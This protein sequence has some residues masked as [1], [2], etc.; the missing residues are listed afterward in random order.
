MRSPT[1]FA[2]EAADPI[3]IAFMASGSTDNG[4]P[5]VDQPG[6]FAGLRAQLGAGR[7]Q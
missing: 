5:V 2:S 1:V 4:P 6:Q 3:S 7:G